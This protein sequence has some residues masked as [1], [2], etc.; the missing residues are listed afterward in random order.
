MW[1]RLSSFI[2]DLNIFPS[3]PPSINEADLHNQR[4][5]TRLFIVLLTLSTIILT[6]YTSLVTLTHTID[7]KTPTFIQ[8]AYLYSIHSQ[9]LV[10]ACSQA[11][12]DYERI[13]HVQYTLHEVCSSAFITDAWIDNL[14]PPD[15]GEN[16][17]SVDFRG[18]AV[19]TFQ[20]L[21]SF[22]EMSNRTISGSLRQFLTNQHVTASVTPMEIFHQQMQNVFQKFLLSVTNDLLL[23]LEMI[24]DVT[25]ANALWSAQ[26]S[27]FLAYFFEAQEYPYVFS[28]VYTDGSCSFSSLCGDQYIIWNSDDSLVESIPGL[29]RGCLITRA[30]LRSTLECF[31]YSWCIEQ[32]WSYFHKNSSTSFPS[33]HSSPSSRNAMNST[34]QEMINNLMVEDW[35]WSITYESYYNHC[36]PVIC[37]YTVVTRNDALYIATTLFGLIGGLMTILKRSVPVTVTFARAVRRPREQR[38]GKMHQTQEK[39]RI[40]EFQMLR[41]VTIN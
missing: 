39:I 37:S 23:S 24:Q 29:Y 41:Y 17:L 38:N 27:N 9:S 36:Q 32:L 25:E 11:S 5:S 7:V 15:V 12:I 34:I 33:L 1:Q 21:R 3:V 40:S 22:C 6:V 13:F 16:V 18:T 4:L 26:L 28:Q 10:C 31:Y 14:S 35:S 19:S 20:A 8:Y 30:L 2:R